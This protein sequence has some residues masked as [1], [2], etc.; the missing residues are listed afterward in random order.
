[1]GSWFLSSPNPPE[2]QRQ[3]GQHRYGRPNDF[4]RDVELIDVHVICEL[5]ATTLPPI[6]RSAYGMPASCDRQGHEAAEDQ[7]SK[8]RPRSNS[9]ILSPHSAQTPLTL[10]VRE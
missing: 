6:G 1:M 3:H 8:P 9:H 4:W 10:P 5:H 2:A 7:Q